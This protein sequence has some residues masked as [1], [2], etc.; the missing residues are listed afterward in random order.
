MHSES[1]LL[2]QR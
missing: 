1:L 2:E